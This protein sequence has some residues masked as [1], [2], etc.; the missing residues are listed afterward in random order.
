[1]NSFS[2][3]LE[4]QYINWMAQSGTRKTLTEFSK[5]LGISQPLINRY[6]SGQVIP[7]EENVHKIAAHLGPEV[8][9][10]LGLARPDENIQRITH[11]WD[12]L[13]DKQKKYVLEQVE[14]YATNS[15]QQDTSP[16]TTLN[17]KTA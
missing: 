16:T 1:M 2:K 13:S 5:W 6:M 9:D 12:K 3:W 10:L 11:L 8:Y 7:S 15:N 17:T 14:K 4:L